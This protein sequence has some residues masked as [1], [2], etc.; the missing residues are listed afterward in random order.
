MKQILYKTMSRK[1]EH[2][3]SYGCHLKVLL[4]GES[5]KTNSLTFGH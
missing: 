2:V 4:G 1:I 5:E 3:E